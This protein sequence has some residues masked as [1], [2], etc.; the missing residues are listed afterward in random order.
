M[1]PRSSGTPC[2]TLSLPMVGRPPRAANQRKAI[3]PRALKTQNGFIIAVEPRNVADAGAA[4]TPR[5]MAPE[6]PPRWGA[7]GEGA[8]LVSPE[9][10]GTGKEFAIVA[11]L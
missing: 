1:A 4:V 8:Q 5:P 3:M 9:A 11:I 2:R 7:A 10:C 6:S